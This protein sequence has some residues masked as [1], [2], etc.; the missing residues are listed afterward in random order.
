MM[1][2]KIGE[3]R[4]FSA[5]TSATTSE[6]MGSEGPSTLTDSGGEDDVGGC[7]CRTREAPVAW[8][9]IGLPLVWLRRR[10]S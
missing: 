8:W 5:G 3:A 9:L 1:V 7:S 6:G 2:G 4:K 10:S